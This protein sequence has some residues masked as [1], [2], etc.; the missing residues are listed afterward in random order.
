MG[1]RRTQISKITGKGRKEAKK[2][3]KKNWKVE[4]SDDNEFNNEKRWQVKRG[5]G[6]EDF[7]EDDVE[8]EEESKVDSEDENPGFS[9]RLNVFLERSKSPKYR[10][11]DCR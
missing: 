4:S 1:E 3:L 10:R 11:S 2:N 6:E 9:G 8:S 7:N 5:S